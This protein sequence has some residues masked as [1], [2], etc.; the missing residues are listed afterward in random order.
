MRISVAMCTYNGALY[1]Q[2]QL[3]SIAVQ[4][5]PPFEL[6]VCDDCSNDNTLTLLENFAKNANFPVRIFLN[7]RN[8]GSTQNFAKAISLCEGDLIALSDQD[9]DWHTNK[10]ESFHQLFLLY[11]E[12]QVAFGNAELMDENSVTGRGL[13]WETTQFSPKVADPYLDTEFRS[14]LFQRTNMVTGATMVLRS[15]FRARFLPI[16]DSWIHD[17]WIVWLAAIEKGV[18]VLPRPAMRYRI[19]PSQQLGLEKGSTMSRLAFAKQNGQQ[20][21]LS[22]IHQLKDLKMYL[23]NSR[24]G[25]QLMELLSMLDTKIAHMATRAGLPD[26]FFERC[27]LIFRAREQYRLYTQGTKSMFRDLLFPSRGSGP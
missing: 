21:Y 11:S 19:H 24:E 1:L 4:T 23:K 15:E 2:Q 25:G 26:S 14:L 22:L 27:L 3:N 20:A 18:A 13:L 8:L 9:D 5:F 16:S 17:G 12:A 10:L 6:V 7:E